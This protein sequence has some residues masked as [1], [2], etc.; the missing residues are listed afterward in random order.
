VRL[1]KPEAISE[2]GSVGIEIE[3]SNPRR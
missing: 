2:A 1:E 3:R